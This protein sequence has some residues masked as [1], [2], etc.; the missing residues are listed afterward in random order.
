[1][2]WPNTA[3]GDVV[4]EQSVIIKVEVDKSGG[5]IAAKIVRDAAGGFGDAALACALR[6]RFLP[7]RNAAGEPVRAWSPPIEVRFSR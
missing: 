1:V 7:A 6:T 4:N 3:S 5:V 2:T